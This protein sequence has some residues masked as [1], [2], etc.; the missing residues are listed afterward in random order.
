[1]VP[2]AVAARAAALQVDA[3]EHQHVQRQQEAASAHRHAQR[4]CVAAHTQT[5]VSP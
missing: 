4:H 1:M 5:D 3:R 2:A